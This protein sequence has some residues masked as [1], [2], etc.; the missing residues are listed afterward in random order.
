MDSH[1]HINHKVKGVWANRWVR[2]WMRFAGYGRYGRLATRLAAWQSPPHK[3][4]VRLAK[5]NPRGFIAPS[6]QIFHS[7]L[8]LGQHVYL[9]DRV[10]IYES[11]QSGPVQLG[12]RVTFLRDTIVET[13]EEGGVFIG[14]DTFIH[15]RCQLN[16][17]KANIEIG[18]GVMLAANCAL[19][20]HNHGMVEGE[21]MQEQ[22]LESKGPIIIEDHCWLGTG[23]VVMGG[24]R[25][26]QGAVIGAGSVVI[27]DI[28]AMAIAVG[29][30]AR[31]IR[32]RMEQL[33]HD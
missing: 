19:Y 5:M 17:Y 27:N 9:G 3:S 18:K 15:P 12:D 11:S 21:S 20:P 7:N 14:A 25:I 16:A 26:G 24:V 32:T 23:V 6:A 22:P 1:Y 33:P 31:V 30:P 4:Q 10:M 8:H 29:A 28:P 2:F 13:G